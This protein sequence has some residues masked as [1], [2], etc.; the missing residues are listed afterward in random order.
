MRYCPTCYQRVAQDSGPR[1]HTESASGINTTLRAD[2]TV[3]FSPEAKEKNKKQAAKLKRLIIVAVSA[4]VVFTAALYT[5]PHL[6]HYRAEAKKADDRFVQARKDMNMTA[7]ALTK[8]KKDI[9]RYPTKDEGIRVLVEKPLT[10]TETETSLYNKW[11][12]PY[13][14]SVREVDPWGNEYLYEP[15]PDGKEYRLISIDPMRDHDKAVRV[16][17]TSKD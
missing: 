15:S 16:V 10:W 3:I 1:R 5:F 12:G 11:G 7:E 2:P 13:V 6:K 17:V 9:G 8:F 14:S 4:F